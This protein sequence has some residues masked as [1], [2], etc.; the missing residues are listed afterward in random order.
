MSQRDLLAARLRQA[1][2]GCT[3][4]LHGPIQAWAA[5]EQACVEGAVQR[6]EV[7]MLAIEA[8]TNRIKDL[9]QA[10]VDP[11]DLRIKKE[12]LT[13]TFIEKLLL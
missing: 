2:Q 12:E 11:S 7:A 5:I 3:V 8:C 10:G 9:R 6:D 13:R 4:H 1:V